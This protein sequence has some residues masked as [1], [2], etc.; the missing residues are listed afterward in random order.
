MTKLLCIL[1]LCGALQAATITITV[2]NDAG[3]TST[4]TITTTDAVIAGSQQG[5][6]GPRNRPTP[7]TPVATPDQATIVKGMIVT[8]LRQQ[9]ITTPA[10]KALED[11]AAALQ[12][13]IDA[14]KQAQV[15]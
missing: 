15:K 6:R 1:S 8:R 10:V 12:K 13:Q 2:T 11:Q 3:K 9:A 5:G 4:A 14:A 7:T